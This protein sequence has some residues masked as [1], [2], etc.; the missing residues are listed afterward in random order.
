MR[1][2]S[3]SIVAIAAL[4]VA[5]PAGGAPVR[6][7]TTTRLNIRIHSIQAEIERLRYEQAIGSDEA[8]ELRRES[9]GLERRLLGSGRR[10]ISDV[11]YGIVRLESRVRFAVDDAR[12]GSHV[13]DRYESERHV[14]RDQPDEHGYHGVY[15]RYNGAPV[16]RWHDPFDRGDNR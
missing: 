13:Y 6:S 9:R 4:V 5:A 11:E 8:A 7:M 16:D 10:D 2:S 3:L 1:K 15:D 12:W 14:D